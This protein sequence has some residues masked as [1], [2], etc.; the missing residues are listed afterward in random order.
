VRSVPQSED[1][2]FYAEVLTFL[3]RTRSSRRRIDSP[4][5]VHEILENGLPASARISL[6]EN[7]HTIDRETV[8]NVLEVSPRT[9]ARSR[10]RATAP[11]S[12][13]ESSNVW[14]LADLITQAK[15]VFGNQEAAERWFLDP[16]LALDNRRPI[17]LAKTAP[18]AQLV[19]EVLTRL[20]YG[21]YT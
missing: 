1:R 12:A 16:A 11:L 9:Y 18:G 5:Q 6:V 7:L 19:K 13:T 17:D 4:H 20:E 8:L 14:R 3:G 21:V 10:K 2:G 15:R